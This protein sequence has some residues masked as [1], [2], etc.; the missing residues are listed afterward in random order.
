VFATFLEHS[1]TLL[2]AEKPLVY[3]RLCAFLRD[4]EARVTVDDERT[5]I[6]FPAGA[7]R[8]CDDVEHPFIELSS[9]RAT[10][11]AVVDG[12]LTLEEAVWG[13]HLELRGHLDDLV[14]FHDALVLY[15]HGAVRCPSFPWLLDRYRDADVPSAAEVERRLER[16][17]P[18]RSQPQRAT[19]LQRGASSQTS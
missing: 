13:E 6:A 10:V 1:M 4:R 19:T 14:R 3:A 11:L 2:A 17:S 18:R 7:F 15:L 12:R 16:T 9:S 5:G 8:L